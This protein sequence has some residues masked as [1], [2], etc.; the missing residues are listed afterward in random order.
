MQAGRCPVHLRHE[1]AK[2]PLSSTICRIRLQGTTIDAGNRIGKASLGKP[3]AAPL[4][5]ANPAMWIGTA[6]RSVPARYGGEM[7]PGG[8]HLERYARRLNAVEI[9]SSFHR[10]HQPKTYERWALCTAANFRFSV[11]LPKAITHEHR[12]VDCGALLDHFAMEVAG[13]R[14]RLGI[15][16]V[17]LPPKALSLRR[18][19]SD[20][21]ANC[22]AV[23]THLSL[24]SQGMG[25]GSR[26]RL[27]TGWGRGRS[28]GLR[29]TPLRCQERTRRAAGM[30]SRISAGMARR[31][32]T[33]PI[34]ML[35]H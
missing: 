24:P 34:T 7:P 20:S 14:D 4:I 26:T 25:V 5:M 21:F 23:S 9:N 35:R 19:L 8:T 22:A 13:L 17:Q 6:G 16:L 2:C 30:R 31:R 18:L 29:R 27:M 1:R 15:L 12:L 28:R 33:S 3:A 10:S 11:K 32:F